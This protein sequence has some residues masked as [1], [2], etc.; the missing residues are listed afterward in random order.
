MINLIIYKS[1]SCDIIEN[2]FNIVLSRSVN[3]LAAHRF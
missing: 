1:N 3:K 2:A